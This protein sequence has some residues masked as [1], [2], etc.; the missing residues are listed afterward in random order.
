MT[1]TPLK[2]EIQ[3]DLQNGKLYCINGYTIE[4]TKWNYRLSH[5][6]KETQTFQKTCV[7]WYSL[8]EEVRLGYGDW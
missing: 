6:D 1:K 3:K 4:S 8:M 5:A 2:Q 7:G